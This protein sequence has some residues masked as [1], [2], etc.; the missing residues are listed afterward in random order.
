MKKE[1]TA[2]HTCRITVRYQPAELKQLNRL[3]KA[4]TCRKISEYIRK[5]SLHKPVTV[6]YR[7]QSADDFLAEMIQLK[8]ELNAI[9]NNLNQAVHKLHTLDR[10]AE[11]RT[12][13]MLHESG[14]KNLVKKVE[15]IKEKMNQ[16]YQQWSQG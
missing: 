4:S 14:K 8:N 12:W 7:N 2:K 11:I 15:E 3:L 13:A 5:T 16:I 10:V 1:E 9:G 6:T